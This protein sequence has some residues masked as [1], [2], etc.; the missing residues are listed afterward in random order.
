[1]LRPYMK[2]ARATIRALKDFG[3]VMEEGVAVFGVF[4]GEFGFVEGS[5]EVQEDFGVAFSWPT[6]S[7]MAVQWPRGSGDISPSIV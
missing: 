1:M 3:E 5:V 6:K 7:F 4:D 2:R